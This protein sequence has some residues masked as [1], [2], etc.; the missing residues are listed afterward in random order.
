[1]LWLVRSYLTC[2]LAWP[3]CL[4]SISIIAVILPASP[5][6]GLDCLKALLVLP[7]YLRTVALY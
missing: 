7:L 6:P 3:A 4:E 1:M 5:A 2:I